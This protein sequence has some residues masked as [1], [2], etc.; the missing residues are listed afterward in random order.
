LQGK[1]LS[2]T[3][4]SPEQDA[5]SLGVLIFQLLMEGNHPF[6][7]QWLGKGDPPP[8]E[9][10]IAVGGFPY[11]STPGVPVRPPKYAPDLDLL[12][13]EISELVRRCFIDGHRDP[14]LRPEASAWEWAITE[15][16]KALVQCPNRHFYSEHLQ[17]CPVC[18]APRA[19]ARVKPSSSPLIIADQRSPERAPLPGAKVCHLSGWE[20]SHQQAIRPPA[21]TNR[22]S[23]QHSP[24]QRCIHRRLPRPEPTGHHQLTLLGRRIN[25]S[26]FNFNTQHSTVAGAGL[27]AHSS[28]HPLPS[29]LRLSAARSGVDR[30][31]PGWWIINSSK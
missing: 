19:P 9:E 31:L 11:T 16:E 2:S 26:I 10:R 12:H 24:T 3:I 4:R 28:G 22:R 1:S 18:H 23:R 7:A 30:G 20:N 5:F 14:R 13:P 17:A 15:A 29:L 21:N 8:L 6:R 25:R 27:S